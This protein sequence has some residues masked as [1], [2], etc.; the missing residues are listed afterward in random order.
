MSALT[1]PPKNLPSEPATLRQPVFVF[2]LAPEFTMN[3]F[4]LATEALRIANQNSG[5]ELFRW[6]VASEQGEPV[7]ASN[8]MWVDAG[9]SLSTLPQCDYLVLLEGNLPTQNISQAML[10]ALRSAYRHGSVI[11]SVDTA[12][13]A[14]AAAGLVG[15][16]ELVIH[17]EAA[18]PY[19]ERYP[20]AML[21]NRIFLVDRQLAFC[22]GGVAMLDLMLELIGSLKG[23]SLSREIANALIHTPREGA[24]VQRSDDAADGSG[25]QLS[26]KLVAIMEDNLDFPLSPKSIARQLGV[27]VRT[28]ERHC[29]RHFEQT[30]A[31][32]YLRIRLQAARSLLF[33][34]ERKISDI[35]LACGF[36]YPSV[37]TRA[38]AAQFGHSPSAFRASFR[39]LQA[40][41]VRPE[42]L[43]MSKR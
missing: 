14:V 12:A 38:F 33:Y 43:R 22:A 30:P 41:A 7:R 27:S 23:A 17:W 37:F 31:Q 40:R 21:R 20:S 6:V 8:G 32:L 3:A 42:I 18:Q 13:F 24:H 25:S 28:L 39:K 29:L 5:Q 19:L 10:A 2:L 16:R 26:R 9:H 34:E 36:S 15:D 4:V 1:G 11:V 35:A